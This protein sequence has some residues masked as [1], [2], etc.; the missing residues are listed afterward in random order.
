MEGMGSPRVCEKR[1][2]G[3]V[4]WPMDTY[5]TVVYVVSGRFPSG[6]WFASMF[7]RSLP[8]DWLRVP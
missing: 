6:T 5:E 7:A 3:K 1:V 2:Y 8:N 4:Q